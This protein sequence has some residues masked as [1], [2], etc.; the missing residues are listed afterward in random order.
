MLGNYLQQMT[1]SDAFFLGAL[2]VK[3]TFLYDQKNPLIEMAILA[4]YNNRFKN[5]NKNVL[6]THCVL[7]S[8]FMSQK[9]YSNIRCFN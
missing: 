3:H 9:A 2:R 1:F 8:I 7:A 5:D 4:T 6:I